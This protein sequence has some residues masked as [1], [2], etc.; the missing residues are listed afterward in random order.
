MSLDPPAKTTARATTGRAT[1]EAVSLA[2]GVSPVAVAA[3]GF[4]SMAIGSDGNVYAWGNNTVGQIG[5]GSVGGTQATPEKVT[6]PT[7]GS[8][9]S[10]TAG[11]QTS[12]AITSA[13]ALYAWGSDND[14]Q[15]GNSTTATAVPSPVPVT[16]LFGPR[17]GRA[18]R[19]ASRRLDC[20]WQLLRARDDRHRNGVRVGRRRRSARRRRTVG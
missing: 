7:T 8:V 13:G 19:W 6:L 4:V 1:P 14:G 2:A 3:G 10:V 20:G 15:L 16:L 9:V 12:F 11:W 18:D 17:K 5:E